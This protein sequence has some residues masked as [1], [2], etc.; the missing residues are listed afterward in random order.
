ME[1][2]CPCTFT[3]SESG[4]FWKTYLDK[5]KMLETSNFS[6][7][8]NV[9]YSTL[10]KFNFCHLQMLLIWTCKKLCHLVWRYMYEALKYQNNPENICFS[11]VLKIFIPAWTG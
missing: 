11:G 10:T 9:F 1:I 7:Y 2:L 3:D 5:E 4:G 6:C 8:Y